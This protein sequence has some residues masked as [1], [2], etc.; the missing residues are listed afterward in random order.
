M[1]RYL[2]LPLSFILLL[3]NF[4]YIHGL[5]G[6]SEDYVKPSRYRKLSQYNCTQLYAVNESEIERIQNELEKFKQ[7][8]Y[9]LVVLNYTVNL[10]CLFDDEM[11]YVRQFLVT[12]KGKTVLRYAAEAEY[13]PLKIFGLKSTIQNVNIIPVYINDSA[14][15]RKA[16]GLQ[17]LTAFTKILLANSG[18][19]DACFSLRDETI[20]NMAELLFIPKSAILSKTAIICHQSD[21]EQE[22]LNTSGL[23]YA[24]YALCLFVTMHINVLYDLVLEELTERGDDLNIYHKDETPFSMTRLIPRMSAFA[25]QAKNRKTIPVGELGTTRHGIANCGEYMLLAFS[26]PV[27]VGYYVLIY[28]NAWVENVIFM[29]DAASLDYITNTYASP[30]VKSSGFMQT[31]FRL[32]FFVFFLLYLKLASLFFDSLDR[33]EVAFTIFEPSHV[34]THALEQSRYSRIDR[35]KKILKQTSQFV[36]AYKLIFSDFWSEIVCVSVSGPHSFAVTYARKISEDERTQSNI[37][38]CMHCL[39]IFLL[40]VLAFFERC[41]YIVCALVNICVNVIFTLIQT[42]CPVLKY[43]F[44]GYAQRIHR[45]SNTL[46]KVVPRFT[47]AV[48]MLLL[49]MTIW[50]GLNLFVFNSVMLMSS[51]FLYLTIV[52]VPFNPSYGVPFMVI[53]LSLISYLIMFYDDFQSDYKHLLDVIF[54][55]LD[56][57]FVK[58]VADTEVSQSDSFDLKTSTKVRQIDAEIFNQLSKKYIPYSRKCAFLFIKLIFTIMLIVIAFNALEES[59]TGI[60][61]LKLS[62]YFSVILLVMIPGIIRNF[63][64]PRENLRRSQVYFKVFKYLKKLDKNKHLE[65]MVKFDIDESCSDS[66][67][68]DDNA[69]NNGDPAD[70]AMDRNSA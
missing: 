69:V 5:P 45:E 30:L 49:Y 17:N 7:N 13:F 4:P 54:E 20:W 48:G 16:Y 62:D 22:D 61:T 64:G 52:A 67:E 57:H 70:P 3:S 31:L 32:F 15:P 26:L 9:D 47:Y 35:E 18:F 39:L 14:H 55:I 56:D 60:E 41:F 1:V 23:V 40:Q 53:V 50:C 25:K 28:Q 12:E 36:R 27:A 24:I 44:T 33:T 58:K 10:D 51:Y 8:K 29:N 42:F 37:H 2:S 63:T 34:F 38:A 43:F 21:S 46:S 66:E 19:S 59:G 68:D 11:K 6:P 65:A